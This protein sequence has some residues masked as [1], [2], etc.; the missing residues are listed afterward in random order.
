M[1]KTLISGLMITVVS[2]AFASKGGGGEKKAPNNSLKTNFTPIRTTT[3]FTLKTGPSFTG[4]VLLGTEK[5][6]NH[7]SFNTLVTYEKG[8]TMY[9]LPYRYKINSSLFLR[10]SSNSSLQLLDL[11]INMSGRK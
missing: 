2:L 1:R 10:N 4:S 11:H 8:N 7:I 3:G 6:D 9:I 5:K